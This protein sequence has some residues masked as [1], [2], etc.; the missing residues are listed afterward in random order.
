MNLKE[1][2]EDLLIKQKEYDAKILEISTTGSQIFRDNPGDLDYI[3]ICEGYNQRRRKHFFKDNGITY[4]LI[5][6]DKSVFDSLYDFTEEHYVSPKLKFFNYFYKIRHT[7]Y[8]GYDDGWNMF[9]HEIEYKKYI[10]KKFNETVNIRNSSF[11]SYGKFYVH[12]YII[13][14]LIIN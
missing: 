13:L 10:A 2:I 14:K 1:Y 3:A 8:G 7:I 12:Y 4:D 6:M 9:D 11:P 5:I